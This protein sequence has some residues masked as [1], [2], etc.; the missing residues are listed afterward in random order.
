MASQYDDLIPRLKALAHPARLRI[1][2]I[3]RGGEVCV[4]HLETALGR[5]QAYVS[6]Q[7]MVLREAGLVEVRKDGQQVY[8]RLVDDL[9]ASLLAAALGPTGNTGPEPLAGC[10]CPCCT[11]VRAEV[12]ARPDRPAHQGDRTTC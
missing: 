5:R 2:D 1:L 4:C 11:L 8:Y 12:L 6:Q 10:P 9:T 7:L 3:L